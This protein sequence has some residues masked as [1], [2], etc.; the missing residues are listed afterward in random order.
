MQIENQTAV[1][2]DGGRN[3]TEVIEL[4][5]TAPSF[6]SA[7]HDPDTE[8][9]MAMAT[10]STADL[11]PVGEL[12]NPPYEADVFWMPTRKEPLPTDNWF[13]DNFPTSAECVAGF[14]TAFDQYVDD[15]CGKQ[16]RDELL[17]SLEGKQL[18]AFRE[19][20]W[21][22]FTI[23][24]PIYINAEAKVITFQCTCHIDYNLEEHGVEV[25]RRDGKWN[26]GYIGDNMEYFHYW[27]NG[28]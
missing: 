11:L 3:P 23:P 7:E 24:D 20:G 9:V 21:L 26:F 4:K 25:S 2:G 1:L 28:G 16:M 12:Y 14:R 8:L 15:W 10:V 13:S 5:L 17:Q 22:P 27:E 6:G 19:H 18:E